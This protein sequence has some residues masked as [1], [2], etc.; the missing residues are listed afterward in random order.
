MSVRAKRIFCLIFIYFMF[1]I[2]N[3]GPVLF[4]RLY[5]SEIYKNN[6]IFFTCCIKDFILHKCL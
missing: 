3:Y 1:F 6:K 2:E 4:G 5:K